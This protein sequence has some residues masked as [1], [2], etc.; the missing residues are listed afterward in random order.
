MVSLSAHLLSHFLGKL[1]VATQAIPPSPLFFHCLQRDSQQQQSGLRGSS[2]PITTHPLLVERTPFQ[3]EWEAPKGQ[4]RSSY[5]QLC[6]ELHRW[7]LVSS[8]T[9][10][11]HQLSGVSSSNASNK[12]L[13][14]GYLRLQMDSG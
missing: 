4:V 11:V 7:Y 13:P 12:D 5:H 2:V 14:E 10:N 3:M 8:G 9:D 1:S 6:E